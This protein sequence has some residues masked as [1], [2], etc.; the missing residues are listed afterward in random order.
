MRYFDLVDGAECG[1]LMPEVVGGLIADVRSRRI[2]AVMMGSP[3]ASFSIVKHRTRAW[4]SLTF[5]MG[6]PGLSE[7]DQF[8]V[9]L[10]NWL[11]RA[12]V[13]I[14]REC[15]RCRVPWIIENP[16]SSYLLKAPAV[17]GLS[18]EARVFQAVADFCQFGARWRK[19]ARFVC[20]RVD[21]SDL[22]RLRRRCH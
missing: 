8:Q 12:A 15:Q 2:N 9:N 10:G 6:V 20:G 18:C 16:R 22:D 19:T 11:M 14:A 3:R 17:M 21:D 5:P 13:R 1:A 4:R 7:A